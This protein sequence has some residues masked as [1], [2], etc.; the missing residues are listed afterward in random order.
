MGAILGPS[1]YTKTSR[2]DELTGRFNGHQ[3]SKLLVQVEEGLWA[4]DK[5]AE[6]AL[7]HMITSPTVR[8]EKKF[9]EPIDIA[10]HGR[11]LFTSNQAWVVPATD[12]E[13]R[14]AVLDVRG[15][16]AN[17]HSYFEAL[18][19]QM[20][21]EGGC[22]RFLHYLL[23][24]VAV[25]WTTL[26]R[27]PQTR[28]LLDQQLESLAPADQW[29]FDVLTSGVL[30]GDTE[31]MGR[32]AKASLFRSYCRTLREAGRP[33][34]AT[35]HRFTRLLQERFGDAVGESRPRVEPGRARCYQFPP[36]IECREKFALHLALTPD[37]PEPAKWQPDDLLAFL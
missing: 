29:L 13:R 5:K 26:S 28:A 32:T 27:P 6:G 18:H 31:G 1:L 30:P 11:L 16:R 17:D 4:G 10:N 14:F 34:D 19:R 21:Q 9:M 24:E 12:N 15:T 22:E 20:F 33:W 3:Q 7:K 25:D 37:W 36:L 35:R 2:P 23:N 8:I